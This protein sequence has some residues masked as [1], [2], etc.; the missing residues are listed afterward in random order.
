MANE[1]HLKILKQGVHVW[2]DWRLNTPYEMPDLTEADLSGMNLTEAIFSDTNLSNAILI[3]ANL[4]R[5]NLTGAN[6]TGADL[7]AVILRYSDLSNADLSNAELTMVDLTAADLTGTVLN[8][9]K[10]G[11]T[12]LAELDLSSAVGLETVVHRTSSS[13][14]IDT[15]YT[16]EG[17]IPEVFLRG[18]GLPELLIQ[19]LPSLLEQPIQF[20]SAFISYSHKDQAF[21]RRLHDSLQGRGVRCWLDEHQVLPGDKIHVEVDRGIRIWDKVL[22]CCSQASLTSW[23]VN[24]E[25]ELAIQKEQRL[26]KER[27]QEVLALMPLDLDGFLRKGDWNSGWKGQITSRLAP[28]FTGWQRSHKKFEEQLE[29]VVKALRADAGARGIPPQPKL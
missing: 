14:G 4:D 23:W 10:F 5:A 18:F 2:N 22:L 28:D 11:Y 12:V 13:L 6:L 15:L 29:R 8:G 3:E 19:Y 25:V 17:A 21:A 16:S 27:S 9:A 20:Y 7:N 1:E 24:N 26:Y